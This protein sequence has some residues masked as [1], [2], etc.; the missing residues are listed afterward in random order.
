[1]L[2]KGVGLLLLIIMALSVFSAGFVCQ[3][4]DVS[5]VQDVDFLYNGHMEWLNTS[6]AC[7]SGSHLPETENVHGGLKALKLVTTPALT[8][9]EKANERQLWVQ[10]ISGLVPG[11]T[12][13]IGAWVYTEDLVAG[14]Y[15]TKAYA[16][17]KIEYWDENGHTVGSKSLEILPNTA[18]WSY[19]EWTYQEVS[20]DCP[21]TCDGRAYIHVRHD[22]IGTVLFDDLRVIGPATAETAESIANK[23][24]SYQE[25][26]D[27]AMYFLNKQEDYTKFATLATD[28]VNFVSNPGF[29]TASA[30]YVEGEEDFY[31]EDGDINCGAK[32][33]GRSR[34]GAS[35]ASGVIETVCRTKEEVHSGEYAM[36][37]HIPDTYT[38]YSHPYAQQTLTTSGKGETFVAGAEYILSS[39]IKTVD[40]A[41]KS[42]AYYKVQ[43]NT[44]SGT[45]YTLGNEATKIYDT[46][47]EWTE[48]KF[49]FTMPE[50]ITSIYIYVR[51]HGPGT[52]YYD[53]VVLGRSS[54]NDPL[55][56]HTEHTFYY[57]EDDNIDATAD[58]KTNIFS[59]EN[60]S[61]V[62]FS[63]E[64]ENGTVVTSKTVAAAENNH[65][66]FPTSVLTVEKAQYILKAEYKNAA[67]TVLSSHSKRIYRFDRPTAI[68][69]KKNYVD[70]VTGKEMYPFFMYG[71]EYTTTD[72]L[73]ASG[74]TVIRTNIKIN[75][76]ADILS[77]LD[78][79]H[80]KG[81]KVLFALYGTVAGHPKQIERTRYLVSTYKDHPAI[82]A[83]ML[84]DEPS[85]HVWEGGILTY[86][87]M[88]YYL[89]EGYRAV[90]EI[91]DVHPV[92]NIETVGKSDNSYER[93]GQ[94]CDIFAIDPYPGGTESSIGGY[95]VRATQRARNAV[96]DE[97]PVWVLGLASDWSGNYAHPFVTPTMLRFQVYDALWAGAKGAGHYLAP[98]EDKDTRAE[99]PDIWETENSRIYNET[100]K[101]ANETGEIKEL[102]EHFSLGRHTIFT[103]GTGNGYRYRAWY[104]DNGEMY[105]AVTSKMAKDE[106]GK[107]VMLDSLVTDIKLVNEDGS[108]SIDGFDATLVNGLS[109]EN[110][111]SS[112]NTFA[113]TLTVGEASLY[114]ITP[115]ENINFSAAGQ[116]TPVAYG[117]EI[118]ENGNCETALPTGFSTS[119]AAN[120]AL[121]SEQAFG[122]G[123]SVKLTPSSGNN[124]SYANASIPVEYNAS[125]AFSFNLYAPALTSSTVPYA[126]MAYKDADGNTISSETVRFYNSFINNGSWL[127]YNPVFTVPNDSAITTATLSLTFIGGSG[128][129]YLD[130]ISLR[131]VTAFNEEQILQNPS[132]EYYTANGYYTGSNGMQPVGNWT[133]GSSQYATFFVPSK[134]EVAPHSGNHA[135]GLGA[136]GTILRN[137]NVPIE[138]GKTYEI[139]FWFNAKNLVDETTYPHIQ[140]Q[141][142][143]THSYNGIYGHETKRF[144]FK[145]AYTKKDNG[146]VKYTAEYTVPEYQEGYDITKA[147]LQY[148][149]KGSSADII[150]YFDDVSVRVKPEKTGYTLRNL[151]YSSSD[152]SVTVEYDVTNHF[153]EAGGTVFYI[154]YNADGRYLKMEKED[155]A[156]DGIH[157][158]RT[159]DKADFASMKVFIWNSLGGMIPLSNVIE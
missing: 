156:F 6:Y 62:T 126:T 12:Y 27:M 67:G 137:D 37:I 18:S 143:G 144:D 133:T 131:K 52:V 23:K 109:E 140:F 98:T 134:N 111:T 122:E 82:A 14:N 103:E 159:F 47:G 70:P 45:Y 90:R 54:N 106:K 113:M 146:W 81:M 55:D 120:A 130:N 58:I 43:A 85:L 86:D 11:Q 96:Y 76:D 95:L 50:N 123:S 44:P 40:V 121:S 29:E 72:A 79:A 114:K 41:Y 124:Y 32:N 94:L 38:A 4:E 19:G 60:D 8:E 64:D 149:M 61:T 49:V 154:F 135:I 3:A 46:K 87:E 53:D 151:T 136:N 74:F 99:Y 153:T 88:L 31:E 42:G 128:T 80:S 21:A 125:Y 68:N 2:K 108:I 100:F 9:D 116:K 152:D 26:Y 102:F 48:M 24:A 147:N 75:D 92:Y 10:T 132:F 158:T 77:K 89:E 63:I 97:R 150:G 36:K 155:A 28:A 39:W 139:S 83:W 73:A 59:I 115:A 7:W 22:G 118:I 127:T 30:Y 138:Y 69:D 5:L 35:T 57:T 16:G 84:M 119:S 142:S 110:L 104:K 93:T 17:M 107:D 33:W 66:T 78:D 65:V 1:M 20:S 117:N 91:D 13:T 34:Y 56:F 105:M 157:I 15:W 112:D 71:A 145:D 25:G 129:V 51:L 141:T 101:I 148:I